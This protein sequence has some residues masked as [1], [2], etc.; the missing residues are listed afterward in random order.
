M[1]SPEDNIK[2]FFSEMRKKDEQVPIPEFAELIRKRPQWRRMLFPSLGAAASI[3]I[4][5]HFYLDADKERNIQE[6]E[7]VIILS[8]KTEIN[9]QSLVS[10]E[11]SINSWESPSDFLIDDFNEW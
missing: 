4:A 10:G 7:L 2:D 6:N 8:G 11:P 9:T 3:L 5:L 1:N